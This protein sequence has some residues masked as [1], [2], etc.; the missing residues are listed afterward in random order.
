M[1]QDQMIK[2][3]HIKVKCIHSLED[4]TLHGANTQQSLMT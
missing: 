2:P 3:H 4:N 1:N